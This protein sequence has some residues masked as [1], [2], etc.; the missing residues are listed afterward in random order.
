MVLK[1]IVSYYI[2][3]HVDILGRYQLIFNYQTGLVRTV[4]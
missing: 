1:K 3:T 2:G 4:T